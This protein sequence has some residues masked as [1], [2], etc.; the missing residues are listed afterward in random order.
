MS[1]RDR[2]PLSAIDEERQRLEKALEQRQQPQYTSRLDTSDAGIPDF[3]NPSFGLRVGMAR[4]YLPLPAHLL[5]AELPP[6]IALWRI[7]LHYLAPGEPPLGLD[8]LGDTVLGRSTGGPSAPDLDLDRY[9]ARDRGVSRRHA[10]LRPT[11][12]R[13]YLIDRGSTNG[14]IHNA[15]PLGKGITHALEDG[16]TVAFGQMTFTV[17]LIDGPGLYRNRRQT[18]VG[19]EVGPGQTSRLDPD[20]LNP[21]PDDEGPGTDELTGRDPQ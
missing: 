16:D 6:D 12:N 11:M 10:L 20:M 1:E 5:H 21:R 18:E 13:L 4:E 14:T 15:V 8:I 17:R 2:K 9:G 19:E 7:E 3:L